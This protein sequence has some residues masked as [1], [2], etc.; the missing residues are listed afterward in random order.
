MKQVISGAYIYLNNR[1]TKADML[2][3]DGLISDISPAVDCSE[4]TV[5]DFN[6]CVVF[7][8]L[9]DV[10]VHLREPGFS[11]KETIAGGT[12]AAAAGGYTTVC[13]M[14]NLDPAPDSMETLEKQLDIIRRDALV[15]VIPYGTITARRAGGQ[16]SDMDAMAD[17]VAGF[18]DDGSGIQTAEVMH[19]AML[20]AKSLGKIIAA[21][22]EDIGMVN[23]G[24]IHDGQ[25]AHEHGLPGISSESEWSQIKRDTVLADITGVKYHVCHISTKESVDIIR[26]AK[27][28]GVD[29][30]C[31]TAPHYL[32]LSDSDLRDCGCFKMNPPL[33]SEQDRQALLEGIAD[34]TIDMIATDHAPHTAEEKSRG[35]RGS[36]MGIVGLETA[37]PV[38]YTELC[39]KNK[40]SLQRLIELM[41]FAPAKRF[42]FESGIE[43]GK[44]A[45]ICIYDL[46]E[47]YTVDPQTFRGAGRSTPFAGKQVFGRCRMTIVNGKIVYSL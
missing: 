29:I 8:G 15:N 23:G 36:A 12:A 26:K 40:I 4:C 14:P 45:N 6:N 39:L 41:H 20:K 38:L 24:C 43:L 37:F 30:T 34:G 3:H 5:L 42:G 17:Y 18:S 28:S 44:K 19:E 21:H 35:L 11:F 27:A 16:L 7:P 46:R 32:V 10:H 33:R 25:Y 9:I 2:L 47:Q 13:A 22:C 31:E 1:L